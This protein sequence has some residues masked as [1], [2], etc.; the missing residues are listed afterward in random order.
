ME[1]T[2]NQERRIYPRFAISIPALCCVV[3]SN[4]LSR[5]YTHDICAGG[6]CL[7]ANTTFPRGALVDVV[8][9][10]LDT[11]ERIYNKGMIVWYQEIDSSNARLGIKLDGF[12][13]PIPLVLR[14]IKILRHY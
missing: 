1:N 11:G 13:K 7:V 3:D 5:G 2:V 14:S 10:M 8:L 12:L 4:E 6:L 9:E